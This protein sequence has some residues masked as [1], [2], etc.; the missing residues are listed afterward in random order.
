MAM[1]VGVRH[2]PKQTSVYWFEVPESMKSVIKVGSEIICQTKKGENQGTVVC[3]MDGISKNEAAKIIGNYFPLKKVIAV[4]VELDISEVHIPW[5]MAGH[6][7]TVDEI[8]NRIQEFYDKGAFGR[9]LFGADNNMLDGY[10]AYLVARMFGHDTIRG[11]YV[12]I[13]KE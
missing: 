13:D 1:Y 6:T 2:E 8:A 4:A 11:F 12:S 3:V 7:P 9:V 10:S 5:E